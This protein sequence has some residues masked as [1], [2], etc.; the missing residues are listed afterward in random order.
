MKSDNPPGLNGSHPDAD[1]ADYAGDAGDA[2]P[3][4]DILAAEKETSGVASGNKKDA[5]A[6]RVDPFIDLLASQWKKVARKRRKPQVL[7][8]HPQLTSITT[9]PKKRKPKVS[10]GRRNCGQELLATCPSK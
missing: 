6:N 10:A 4:T 2:G 1:D 5:D 8:L 3:N 7:L 9:A